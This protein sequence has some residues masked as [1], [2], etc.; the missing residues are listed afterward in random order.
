MVVQKRMVTE[1]TKIASD[2]TQLAFEAT[3]V[4]DPET[5]DLSSATDASEM[6]ASSGASS[7][8][9]FGGAIAVSL[10]VSDEELIAS[11]LPE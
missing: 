9:T 5:V 7:T 10:E 1:R 3:A 2:I 11:S 6:E 8:S 4:E